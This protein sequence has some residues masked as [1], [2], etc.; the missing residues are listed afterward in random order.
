MK[1]I[2]VYMNVVFLCIKR[3]NTKRHIYI[4]FLFQHHKSTNS[5]NLERITLFFPPEWKQNKYSPNSFTTKESVRS[6]LLNLYVW[7][8]TMKGVSCVQAARASPAVPHIPCT[9]PFIMTA[10]ASTTTLVTCHRQKQRYKASSPLPISVSWYPC[11]N[12]KIQKR[13]W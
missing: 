10:S 9:A 8:R 7:Q 4:F 12:I 6:L 1:F 13:L 3:C 11:I 5:R 2:P